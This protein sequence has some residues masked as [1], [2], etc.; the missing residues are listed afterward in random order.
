[1]HLCCSYEAGHTGH[2]VQPKYPLGVGMNRDYALPILHFKHSRPIYKIPLPQLSEILQLSAP[3]YT[4]QGSAAEK[5]VSAVYANVC[6]QYMH[7]TDI[8]EITICQKDV[9]AYIIYLP[10][11]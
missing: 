1:M 7:N 4:F 5:C 11:F 10:Y 3:D 9:S 2:A 8:S 6:V